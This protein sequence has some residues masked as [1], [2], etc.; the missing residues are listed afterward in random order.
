MNVRFFIVP[1]MCLSCVNWRYV[2]DCTNSGRPTLLLLL[3]LLLLWLLLLL[4]PVPVCRLLLLLV[5]LTPV[6][7][8]GSVASGMRC[9]LDTPKMLMVN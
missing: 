4:T 3:L 7:V 8:C 2:L 5:L 6:P 9:L 1:C